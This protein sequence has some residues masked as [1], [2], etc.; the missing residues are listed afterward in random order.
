MKKFMV[1]QL[2]VTV[3]TLAVFLIAL[4]LS[5]DRHTAVVVTAMVAVF[6][7]SIASGCITLAILMAMLSCVIGLLAT[8][9]ALGISNFSGLAIDAIDI[10]IFVTIAAIGSF[11]AVLSNLFSDNAFVVCDDNSTMKISVALIVQ[12]FIGLIILL[13]V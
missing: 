12:F 2:F 6:V 13:L 8:L 4:R 9:V 11:V 3:V 7:T 1:L 5:G 10:G